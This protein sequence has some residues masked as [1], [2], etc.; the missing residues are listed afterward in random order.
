MAEMSQIE[1]PDVTPL[2]NVNLVILVMV[3]AIAAHAA[4]LLPMAIEKAA[5]NEGTRYVDMTEA[6]VLTVEEDG[7][8]VLEGGEAFGPDKLPATVAGL[9]SGKVVLISMHPKANYAALVKV[10]DELVER[11]GLRV[12]FGHPGAV[13]DAEAP[14]PEPKED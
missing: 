7:R 12:A 6:L 14:P 1:E 2:I 11:P 9:P 5:E 4:R 13:I 3:L 10:V 8:Y